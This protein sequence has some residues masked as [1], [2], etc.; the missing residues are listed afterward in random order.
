MIRIYPSCGAKNR[1]APVHLTDTGRCGACRNPLPPVAEP[2][3]VGGAEFDAIVS[4]VQVPVLVDFWAAWCGPCKLAAPE[5]A[6]TAASA[7]GRALVLKVD[8]ERHPDLASRF[9]VRNIPNFVVLKNGESVAQH[10]GLVDHRR[11]LAWLEAAS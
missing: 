10:A 5:V 8:T 2:L 9:G 3:D 6:H 7:S 1:V 11:M 4:A